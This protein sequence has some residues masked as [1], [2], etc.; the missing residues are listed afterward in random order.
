MGIYHFLANRGLDPDLANTDNW[1]GVGL[2]IDDGEISNDERF[3]RLKRGVQSYCDDEGS[4][5]KIAADIG[6]APTTLDRAVKRCY[7]HDDNGNIVGWAGLI[8]YLHLNGYTRRSPS[9]ENHAGMFQYLLEKTGI[10]SELRLVI[11]GKHKDYGKV[12]RLKDI[13]GIFIELLDQAGAAKHEYPYTVENEGK[14][15]LRLFVKSVRDGNPINATNLLVSP[16]AARKIGRAM[17]S[18]TEACRF[19]DPYEWVEIDAHKIDGIIILKFRSLDGVPVSLTLERLWIIALIEV[20]SKNILGYAFAFGRNPTKDD[21]AEATTRSIIP[22]KRLDLTIEGLRYTDRGGFPTADVDGCGYRL[23]D[24][25]HLDNDKAHWANALHDDLCF[26]GGAILHLG[27]GRQPDDRP[28]IENWFKTYEQD[29]LHRFEV[30]TGS[31]PSDPVRRNPEEAAIRYEFDF[32]ILNQTTDVWIADRNGTPPPGAARSAPL[33]YL[34]ES[35][36][37]SDALPRRV[38]ADERMRWS[39][40]DEWVVREVKGGGKDQAPPYIKYK[41]VRYSSDR[42]KRRWDLIGENVRVKIYRPD[43]QRLEIFLMDGSFF[44]TVLIAKSWRVPHSFFVRGLY[45]KLMKRNENTRGDDI[46][47]TVWKALLKRARKCKKSRNQLLHLA[48]ERPDLANEDGSI[49]E[50]AE[51]SAATTTSHMRQDPRL[52]T[53]EVPRRA[54]Y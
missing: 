12:R 51:G 45:T 11:E 21:V 38:P 31:S 40:H 16:A 46:A 22:Q 14:E 42:L 50:P 17:K 23:F 25:L 43:A 13:H 35:I 54:I 10:E 24:V 36:A 20:K 18:D 48:Q 4:F 27:K 47:R 5:R 37:L 15:G 29:V 44:D 19:L 7:T 41:K 32:D 6:V 1:P 26:K 3:I 49:S 53:V 34:R 33:E 52:D 2:D 8:K 30:T 39:L 9:G 28:N